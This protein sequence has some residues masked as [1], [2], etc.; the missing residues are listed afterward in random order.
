ML[1][2]VDQYNKKKSKCLR[3]KSQGFKFK[4]RDILSLQIVLQHS[5]QTETSE[6][7]PEQHWWKQNEPS[8]TPQPAAAQPQSHGGDGDGAGEGAGDGDGG[9]STFQSDH[10]WF[11]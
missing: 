4:V 9:G 6:F 7:A 5:A 8:S 10:S 1:C 3:A 2:P 11:Q